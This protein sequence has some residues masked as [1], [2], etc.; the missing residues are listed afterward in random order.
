MNR[1]KPPQNNA[2]TALCKTFA[3]TGEC[4]FGDKCT[5]AHGRSELRPK[6][7]SK[8]EQPCWWFN[9]SKGCSKSAEE[10]SFQHV[11]VQNIRKPLHLQHPCVW[12]H[13][14]S[15]GH[16]RRKDE[17]GGDHDY[18]LNADEWK[19]HFP[20][21]KYP[22]EGYLVMSV[23]VADH[24]KTHPRKN[25]DVSVHSIRT[26]SVVFED[27]DFPVLKTTQV[28]TPHPVWSS[29]LPVIKEAPTDVT[30]RQF[31]MP[32]VVVRAPFVRR[33][34][35]FNDDDEDE[36][37]INDNDK[38]SDTD[39][40]DV[41]EKSE[42]PQVSWSD[43]TDD[44]VNGRLNPKA[45]EFVP[46]SQKLNPNAMEFMPTDKKLKILVNNALKQLLEMH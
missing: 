5:F 7:R 41:I 39:A 43:P 32:K 18:E 29:P 17:C 36:M 10:C 27:E 14:R 30:P 26:S 35:Y 2:K 3:S 46:H 22:G 44:I 11:H 33:N 20:E 28:N 1:P 8:V 31:S 40:D 12:M 38:S 25:L 42:E 37:N 4:R 23:I 34:D 16:C 24:L 45:T 21:I 9:Q 15:P 19:H 13:V 6:P